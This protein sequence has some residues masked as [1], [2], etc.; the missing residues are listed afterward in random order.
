MLPMVRI[1]VFALIL[2][3][4]LGREAISQNTDQ[5]ESTRK[6]LETQFDFA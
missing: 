4:A 6:Q 1:V 3:S 2:I 5:I